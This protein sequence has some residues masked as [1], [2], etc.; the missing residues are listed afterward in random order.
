MNF[1]I[2]LKMMINTPNHKKNTKNR[3]L[4]RKIDL[5][6]RDQLMSPSPNHQQRPT[7]LLHLPLDLLKLLQPDRRRKNLNRLHPEI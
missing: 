2:V 7:L 5:Q 6:N 3:L 1:M 4:N